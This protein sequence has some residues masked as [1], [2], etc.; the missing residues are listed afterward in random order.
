[1]KITKLCNL[2]ACQ[3]HIRRLCWF[4][5]DTCNWQ[6]HFKPTSFLWTWMEKC[7]NKKRL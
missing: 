3:V 7:P 5:S 1:M 6:G 2:S 4:Y